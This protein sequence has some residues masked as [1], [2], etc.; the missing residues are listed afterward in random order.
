MNALLFPYAEEKPIFDELFPGKSIYALPLVGKMIAE[1]WL[2]LCSMLRIET[3]AIEDYTFD[4]ECRNTLGNGENW[5]LSLRYAGAPLCRDLSRIRESHSAF[6]GSGPTLVA[7]GAV[8]PDIEKPERLLLDRRPAEAAGCT[9]EGLYLWEND[10]FFNLPVPL[11]RFGTP[12][13]Y[14]ELNFHLLNDPG[15]YVLPGYSAEAGVYTG[16]NVVIMPECSIAPPVMLCD[17]VRLHRR[18]RLSGG[19]I[20]GGD[21]V[22]DRGTELKHAVIMDHTFIG[23]EMEIENKIVASGR[24]I[25]PFSGAYVDHADGLTM[26]IRRYNRVDWLRGWEFVLA[27]TAAAVLAIPYAAIRLIS[28]LC[29]SS[30]GKHRLVLDRYPKLWRVLTGRARLIRLPGECR[31]YVLLAADGLSGSSDAGQIWIDDMY[32][33][34]NRSMALVLR[35]FIRGFIN[36]SIADD[37]P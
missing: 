11:H 18:C 32:F 21:V 35:V 27:L 19:V 20:V 36:R 25:D 14:F 2:D 4:R 26:D 9:D 6:L 24:V 29:G 28:A 37:R 30:L 23:M 31:D 12:Q 8:L 34:H 5:S 13:S 22:V 3:V 17:N 10:R 7:F 16:M 1:Y 15:I 33:M